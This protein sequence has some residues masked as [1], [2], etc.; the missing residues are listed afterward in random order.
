M[1]AQIGKAVATIES[2][3]DENGETSDLKPLFQPSL[4]TLPISMYEQP[5]TTEVKPKAKPPFVCSAVCC[6]AHSKK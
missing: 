6:R 1:M 4:K 5:R 2:A 3:T